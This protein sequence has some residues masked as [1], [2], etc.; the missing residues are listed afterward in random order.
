MRNRICLNGE[1]DFAPDNDYCQP[2]RHVVRNNSWEAVKVRVP[3]SWRSAIRPEQEFQPYDLFNYPERWNHAQSGVV[4]RTFKASLQPGERCFLVLNGVMQRFAVFVNGREVTTSQESFLPVEVDITEALVTE[5]ENDLRIWCGPYETVEKPYGNKV[6]TPS[7]SWFAGMCRGIWQD[8]FLE[9]RPFLFLEDVCVRTSVRQQKIVVR[10]DI[11]Q[12]EPFPKKVSLR[13]CVFTGQER[14]LELESG[15]LSAS[16]EGS[17]EVSLESVWTNPRLWSPEHPDLYDLVVELEVDGQVIDRIQKRFGFREVWLEQQRFILNGTR[18]NLR[19]DAWH[20]QGFVQQTKEF[21][22]NWYRAC[23]DVGVN[24][25]RLHAMPYPEFYLEAADEVGMLIIDES[26]IYGS[27]KAMQADHPDFI[28]NCRQHLRRLVR[29][30]RSHPSVVIWSMQNEMR[31]VDGRDGYKEAMGDLTRCIK[32]LDPTR[33][34]SYDGDNRL[35]DPEH[36]EIVSMHYNIDGTVRSWQKD[37]PLIFGEHGPWHYVSPQVSADL[38]GQAA[39]LSYESCQESMGWNEA[40]FNEYARKE[41]V[42]GLTPFNIVNYNMWSFPP[43]EQALVWDDLTTPGVKPRK[44]PAHS[45]TVNNGLVEGQP[46]NIPNP[47]WKHLHASFKPVTIFRN[48]YDQSFFGGR[49]LRRSFSIYNDTE[50]ATAARLQF[51]FLDDQERELDS[52]TVEFEHLPGERMEWAHE[53]SLPEVTRRSSFRLMLTLFHSGNQVHQL[54]VQYQVFPGQVE[55]IESAGRRIVLFGDKDSYDAISLVV[56]DVDWKREIDRQSM[57]AADVMIIGKDYASISGEILAALEQFVAS[58]GFLILLEQNSLSLGDTTLSG[59]RF[60]SAFITEPS[61][62]VFSGLSA[63][64]LRFWSPENIHAGDTGWMVQN[65]LNKPVDGDMRILLECGEGNFGWGG[66]LWTPLVE[67]AVGQGGILLNQIELVGNSGQVPQ[68]RSLLRNMLRYALSRPVPQL[69][70]TWLVAG[71]DSDTVSFLRSIGLRIDQVLR[72]VQRPFARQRLPL[73][74][75]D[76]DA[77]DESITCEFRSL[78]EAGAQVLLLPC[79][80]EH[81]TWINNL[82]DE[83][84]EFEPGEIY[85]VRA[86]EDAVPRSIPASDLFWMDKV[87]YSP[88]SMNN[89]PICEYSLAVEGAVTLL[90]SVHNPWHDYFIRGLDAEFQKVA[91]ATANARADFKPHVYGARVQI[92]MGNLYFCQVRL[93]TDYA[94]SRRFYTRL[95]GNLGAGIERAFLAIQKTPQDL[96]IPHWMGLEQAD[97]VDKEAMLTYFS[98]ADY[99]LNNLGEGVYG[100]MRRLE[101]TKA[102]LEKSQDAIRISGS[103]GKTWFLTVFVESVENHNPLMRGANELPDSSI[104][105]D[106]YVKTN[107]AFSLYANGRLM[108]QIENPA[109]IVKIE[110]VLLE[111]GINRLLIV[112]RA[113]ADDIQLNAWFRNKYGDPVDGLRY[114]LTLD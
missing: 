94:K 88:A 13:A 104:V 6:L 47:S 78:L 63:E 69:L 32:T 23:R 5:T 68:A 62:P 28:E 11:S 92:G 45:L 22:L 50:K 46:L 14:V 109:E 35:V 76:P 97:Y 103:A 82:T 56:D 102:G 53:F 95:L 80:P 54:H 79:K 85:Q 33:P 64:D 83:V 40:L 29:R 16:S 96:D 61:H 77:L 111:K 8:A 24:I 31:W 106:F 43:V 108:I 15:D 3:S 74:I 18:L 25:V 91:I 114:L 21:A 7:G 73:I 65:A 2:P 98:A 48:E 93:I 67:V 113:G 70:E 52:G 9:F 60:F 36:M 10:A 99:V 89:I 19:G 71:P 81:A 26:A 38:V 110:D 105:P 107:C 20:Y 58:G 34:V 1:W 51:T 87:T 59:K 72:H 100:W 17:M 37:K 55:K 27:G 42:T 90:E 30:D 66:L 112:C 57:A 86:L 4:R 12:N 75:V 101:R 41:Q 44:I 49:S 39:Y 84:V